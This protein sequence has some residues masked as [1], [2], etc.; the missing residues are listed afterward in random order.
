MLYRLNRDKPK[1]VKSVPHPV[2]YQAWVNKLNPG[3]YKKIFN[4]L[5][6]DLTDDFSVGTKY[7]DHS[8]AWDGLLSCLWEA[9]GHNAKQAGYFL[10]IMMMDVLIQDKDKWCCTKTNITHRDFDTNYYW[11]LNVEVMV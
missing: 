2:E 7:P 3:E 10:G 1:P 9:T 5:S 8:P 4:F 6:N 11:R